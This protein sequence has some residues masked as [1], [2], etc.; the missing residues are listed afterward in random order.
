MPI[1][2]LKFNLPDERADHKIALNGS[3]YY[4]Q[5]VEIEDT[6]RAQLKYN[7]KLSKQTTEILEQIRALIDIIDDDIS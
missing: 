4:C 7:E 6:I 3:K 5:L 1:A 2:I